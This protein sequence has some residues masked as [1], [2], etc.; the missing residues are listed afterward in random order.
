MRI[1]VVFLVLMIIMCAMFQGSLYSVRRN[2][3][4]VEEI[5]VDESQQQQQ[6][7]QQQQ[8]HRFWPMHNISGIN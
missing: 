4:L 5:D 3:F 6:Q 2:L 8:H 7:Q 1:S